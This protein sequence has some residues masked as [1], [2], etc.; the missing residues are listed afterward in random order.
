MK[1]HL[2]F[3]LALAS[4][5]SSIVVTLGT[6]FVNEVGLPFAWLDYEWRNPSFVEHIDYKGLWL[7]F[8][9]WLVVVLMLVTLF[10]RFGRFSFSMRKTL[11]ITAIFVLLALDWA[12][13]HDIASGE[14]APYGEYA[15]LVL[16]FLLFGSIGIG[17]YK[18]K[19]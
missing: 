9:F 17:T 2:P 12:A 4:F 16:S 13:L 1:K 19:L 11:A 10:N 5:L 7:D 6:Y 18:K 15:I 8:F 14:P 3:I